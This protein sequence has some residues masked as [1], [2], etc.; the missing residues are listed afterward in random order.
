MAAHQRAGGAFPE[1]QT[2]DSPT[3]KVGGT[4]STEFTAVDH[5]QRMESLD[6]AFSFEELDSWYARL[7]RDGVSE[8]A[9]LCEL[10]VDGLAINL[11]YEGG[12]LVR[13]LT[14]GDGRTGED[15]TPNVK[16]IG[17]IPHRL[18]PSDEFPVPDLVEVRGEVFL[19]IEAFDKLNASLVE[20]GKPMF[21][22]PRNSAA[23]SLRQKDPRV[24]ASR[25][26][27]MVCHGIGAREGFE[28]VAQS[29]AYDALRAWG[30][31]TSD[32]V[33]VL[34]TLD[35]VKEFVGHYGEHRHDVTE[36]EID[37]VVIKVDDI[38]L[39]RRLG[40]TSRAPRWAIAYKY[41]PEEVN[42]KL[43]EIRVNVGRT[44]R[45]TPYGVMEPTKVAGSTVERATLHNAYEVR[46]KDVRPGD[47]V[48]LRKAGDV[49]PEILGPVLPLRPEGL[50]EW[51]M[52][53]ECPSCGT[54]LAEQKEGDK[55]LRCP[56]HRSCR[57]QVLER[58]YH[59]ASR[60]AFDIEGLGSEAAYALVEAG[61]VVNE[62]DVFDLTAE[63]LLR[64]PLF[65]RAP[66]KN[67]EGPQLTANA[68]GLLG[69]LETRKQVPLWRVLVAL[70]IR[71]V[72]PTAARAL[73]TEFGSMDAIRAASEEQLAAAEGVGPTIAEAV[74]EWFKVD[75]HN[76]IVDKW[77]AAG[78]AMA[79]ERDESVP[80]TLEGLTVVVTGSLEGFSR[81]SAKEA[82]LARGGK[83]AGSVSKKTDYVVVG[84]NAGS[85]AD[86]AEQLGVPV[87]DE[88]GFV[89]L[90]EGGAD[91]L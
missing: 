10:K 91:A 49:I 38:A 61:V 32:R 73:A 68:V 22:N 62:G 23:G 40:S 13:A 58:V 87:L 39:Q 65:T 43:L 26:L 64:A 42:T 11:L 4:F 88:A 16:T 52:P 80:R 69:N 75:W 76:E 28:P 81:D 55:D 54:T 63:S 21:A 8:P 30:L 72:G 71:H 31:P 84:D 44:G 56:N 74:I 79:D 3:Q 36:H 46:R 15:V 86:K 7:A 83:A 82:I 20:A 85:K 33:R 35:E 57:A 6:N 90:L 66:K 1:L 53:T 9:L 2:P 59:V 27:G 29:H 78:V 24:T 17:V 25:D 41:P 5:L 45:V 70:S 47:T 12:R 51:E 48:I 18:T 67:E 60:G 37:G 14:R 50:P 19:S 77:Q 89:K 34:P